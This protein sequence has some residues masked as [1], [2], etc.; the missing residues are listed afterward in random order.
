MADLVAVSIIEI[1]RRPP[2][3]LVE[4]SEIGAEL[5]QMVSLWPDV[6]VDHIEDDRHS[7]LM[8]GIDKCLESG[9]TAV[10][11]LN[12]ERKYSVITP[13]A[14]TR[15]LRNRHQFHRCDPKGR[16]EE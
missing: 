8:A 2:W 15:K 10:G 12:R 11:I 1:K 3:C 14:R 7:S 9:G 4:L 13:V 16:S 5:R 6:V